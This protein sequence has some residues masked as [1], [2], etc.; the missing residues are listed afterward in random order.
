MGPKAHGTKTTPCYARSIAPETATYSKTKPILPIKQYDSCNPG[1]NYRHTSFMM[2][3]RTLAAAGGRMLE[4][5][6]K[7]ALKPAR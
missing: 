1:F 7:S 2:T 5:I 4:V 3:R 6:A